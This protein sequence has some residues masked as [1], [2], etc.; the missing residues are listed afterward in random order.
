MHQPE[1]SV[2]RPE[3][4]NAFSFVA[5]YF[6][7]GIVHKYTAPNF[8]NENMFS[9]FMGLQILYWIL[10]KGQNLCQKLI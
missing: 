7:G 10:Y 3:V 9:Y 6:H 8:P 1:N 4:F 2:E 5:P